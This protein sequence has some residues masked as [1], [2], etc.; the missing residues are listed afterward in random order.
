MYAALRDA[1]SAL[2]LCPSH[3]GA[4]RRRLCCLQHLK[5]NKAADHLLQAYA[6]QYPNDSE[7]I[8]RTRADLEQAFKTESGNVL[9]SVYIKFGMVL[10]EI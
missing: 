4:L 3:Q 8:R 1:E 9:G 5:W 7:F 6:E 2:S 10:W